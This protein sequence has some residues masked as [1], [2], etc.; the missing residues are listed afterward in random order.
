MPLT[1]W[2]IVA[3]D[4]Y[5]PRCRAAALGGSLT[6]RNL[7]GFTRQNTGLGGI[8][9]PVWETRRASPVL[10]L[11][12]ISATSVFLLR[13]V[14]VQKNSARDSVGCPGG[15]KEAMQSPLSTG[16]CNYQA[17]EEERLNKLRS[18]P[19]GQ[20]LLVPP[21][22]KSVVRR[23]YVNLT[24]DPWRSTFCAIIRKFMFRIWT[25]RALERLTRITSELLHAAHSLPFT[26]NRS[27]ISCA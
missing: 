2:A 4:R 13:T 22:I 24:D 19:A 1:R 3:S 16:N 9:Q 12:S 8:F 27:L 26:A 17:S 7:P 25:R 21:M 23:P 11:K 5:P 18:I 10:L 6:P 15:G 20:N 14:R